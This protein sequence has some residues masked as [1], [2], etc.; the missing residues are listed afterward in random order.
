MDG[1]ELET[2]EGLG[3][4]DLGENLTSGIYFVKILQNETF[5]VIRVVKE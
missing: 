1:F 5:K 2:G 3:N 4:I